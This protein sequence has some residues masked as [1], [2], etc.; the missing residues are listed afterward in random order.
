MLPTAV[1]PM[2]TPQPKP[3]ARPSHAGSSA[4]RLWLGITLTQNPWKHPG[5]DQANQDQRQAGQAVGADAQVAEILGGRPVL[6]GNDVPVE[7]GAVPPADLPQQGPVRLGRGHQVGHGYLLG[8]SRR[9]LGPRRSRGGLG[10]RRS[11]GGLGLRRSRRA[12]PVT[13]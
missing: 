7:D 9:G 8:G 11:R 12:L 6:A 4:M 13:A 5:Q 3:T 2:G 10:P 1:N